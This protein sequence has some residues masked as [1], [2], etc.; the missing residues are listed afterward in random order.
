MRWR[1]EIETGQYYDLVQR[2][3]IKEADQEPPIDGFEYYVDAFRELNTSR[4][5]GLDLAAIPFTAIVDYFKIY[6]IGD[7]DE[8]LYVIRR[9]D[10]VFIELNSASQ[11]AEGG[12]GAGNS[13]A[14]NKNQGGR[15]RGQSRP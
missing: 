5:V 1:K 9:M 10:D 2:G 4:P 15:A 13:G 7:F 8:F 12:K 3:F 6:G 11:K 14:T